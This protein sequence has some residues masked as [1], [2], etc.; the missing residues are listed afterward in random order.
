MANTQLQITLTDEAMRFIQQ[1]ISSGEYESP[2][3]VILESLLRFNEPEE[4]FEAWMR[5]NAA[6]L[7]RHCDEHPEELLTI[8]QMRESVARELGKLRTIR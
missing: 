2:S 7:A 4:D 5:D 6:D 1:M 8:D 3:D